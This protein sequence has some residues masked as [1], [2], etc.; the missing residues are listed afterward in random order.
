MRA[1]GLWLL[2]ALTLMSCGRKHTVRLPPPTPAILG[3]GEV[4]VASWYGHP[5]HGRRTSNGEVYD[6]N[7]MT[8]AHLS[9]PFG[10]WVRVT[11]LTNNRSTEV[12]INDRGPFVNDRVID[13]SRAA[14][15]EIA[16]IGPGTARVR[17]EVIATPAMAYRGP[18]ARESQSSS[19]EVA[20]VPE[21]QGTATAVEQAQP[22]LPATPAV[23]TDSTSLAA[24]ASDG[25]PC[26]T[27]PYFGVQ[28]GTFASFENAIRLQGRL[29]QQYGV[30]EVVPEQGR[31][32]PLYRV[33][34]GRTQDFAAASDL[35]ASLRQTQVDGFVARVD[36]NPAAD[37][38]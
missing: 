11:N 29:M 10:T 5:Y 26:A 1:I 31:Q 22:A 15:R 30:A 33:I 16:M 7:L 35:L 38:L 20:R 24:S 23:Q 36:G 4:G 13:L 17:V 19:V 9:L 12:R 6:M 37:C 34:V 8:A 28:V 25:L 32:G 18:A 14:A 3:A 27:E 21:V 2:A